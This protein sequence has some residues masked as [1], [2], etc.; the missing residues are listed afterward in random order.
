MANKLINAQ[1]PEKLYNAA[2]AK[3]EETGI[4]L[5]HVIRQGLE[6]FVEGEPL[7][8]KKAATETLKI[9]TELRGLISLLQEKQNADS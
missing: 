3:S 4:A 8:S 5:S 2:R 9:I 1:I 6:D 7:M